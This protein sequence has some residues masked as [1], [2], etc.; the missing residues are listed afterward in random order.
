MAECT[1][2]INRT[3]H[4]TARST[5][6]STER[7]PNLYGVLPTRGQDAA[8][9]RRDGNGGAAD[10]AGGRPGEPAV[11]AGGVER[12]PAGRH[13]APPLPGARG[14]EA[15][16]ARGGGGGPV[17][18][19]RGGGEG[20][21]REAAEV[22]GREP[23]AE[24]RRRAGRRD[25]VAAAA[26]VAEGARGDDEDEEEHGGRGGEEEEDRDRGRHHRS[27]HAEG[28]DARAGA[29]GPGAGAPALGDVP[30][31]RRG[32]GSLRLLRPRGRGGDDELARAGRGGRGHFG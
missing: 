5:L 26:V 9:P 30:I 12:V 15:H 1:A 29:L 20:E 10:G 16:G 19:A 25:A 21:G 22:G 6:P 4:G 8:S 23:R 32:R 14:L 24:R 13:R 27:P 28:Q 31:M 3:R 11:D 18:A 7:E 17:A 2:A